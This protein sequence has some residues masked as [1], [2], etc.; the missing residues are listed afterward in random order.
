[1]TSSTCLRVDHA[2][3]TGD[4]RVLARNHHG[5]V[6]V[7]DLDGQIV[8][9]LT[10]KLLGFL[11]DHNACAMV[12]IDDVVAFFEGA[13]DRGDLLELDRVLSS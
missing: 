11:Q 3:Q 5:H 13:L 10:Q 9:G 7:E 1:M 6:V 12:R 8:P 4:V 2:A